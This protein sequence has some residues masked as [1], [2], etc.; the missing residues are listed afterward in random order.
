MLILIFSTNTRHV[1]KG[2]AHAADPTMR[3]GPVI[4]GGLWGIPGGPCGSMR[5][6]G[7]SLGPPWGPCC[8]LGGLLVHAICRIQISEG[9]ENVCCLLVASV[10]IGA[11]EELC[12]VVKRCCKRSLAF[13]SDHVRNTWTPINSRF[14]RALKSSGQHALATSHSAG[15][16]SSTWS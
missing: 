12:I 16:R 5:G 7:E 10:C 2:S 1:V 13:G 4:L 8:S 3:V 14:T 6:S 9:S 11:L 15:L